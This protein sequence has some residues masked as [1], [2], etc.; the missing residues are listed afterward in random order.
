M[1]V[2][3]LSTEAPTVGREKP[4]TWKVPDAPNHPHQFCGA[5]D[6]A[7]TGCDRRQLAG[8]SRKEDIGKFFPLEEYAV[9]GRPSDRGAFLRAMHGKAY[10]MLIRHKRC[11]RWLCWGG[12]SLWERGGD[13][14][15]ECP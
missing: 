8:M 9:L 12:G 13:W 14:V 4:L 5:S 15:M 6:V 2:S 1:G 3:H 7:L 10:I 11:S